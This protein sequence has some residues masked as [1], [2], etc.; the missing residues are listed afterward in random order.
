MVQITSL[1]LTFLLNSIR[2][3]GM[4][5]VTGPY[6]YIYWP[7]HTCIQIHVYICTHAHAYTHMRTNTCM[8]THAYKYMHIHTCIH[9]HSFH[10]YTHKCIQV[11]VYMSPEMCIIRK[12]VHLLKVSGNMYNPW[13]AQE[14]Y[15]FPKIFSKCTY[16]LKFHPEFYTH[17]LTVVEA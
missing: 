15:T 8:H 6:I 14:I 3:F 12:C 2:K 13:L 11:H 7:T 10:T 5:R 17:L 1:I 4:V 16:F 9:T